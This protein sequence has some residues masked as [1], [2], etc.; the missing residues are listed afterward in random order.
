MNT[1]VTFVELF[2]GAGGLSDGFMELGYEPIAFIEQDKYCCET[3]KTR[4]AYYELKRQ[5]KLPQYNAYLRGDMSKQDFYDLANAHILD[6]VINRTID[7][8]STPEVISHITQKLAGNTLDLL[9]GGPPCQAYS[10]IGRSANQHKKADERRHLYRYYLAFLKKLSPKIFLFENVPGLLT[11]E[12]GAIYERILSDFKS[13]GYNISSIVLD[14]SHYKVLQGRKRVIIIGSKD[15]A[16]HLPRKNFKNNFK[17]ADILSDLSPLIPGAQNSRYIGRPTTYLRQTKIRTN[18]RFVTLHEAR[19]HNERDLEI[20]KLV[21]RAWNSGKKRMRYCELPTNLKTHRNESSFSDRFKVV[22]QDLPISHTMM[23]H[24][25]KDGHYY[26]HPDIEQNR[27]LSVREAA[28]VQSFP[29]NYFFEGPR[30]AKFTQIG[31]A[32]PPLVSKSIAQELAS[33]Y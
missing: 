6:K 32:V 26:I 14:A 3:L 10:I 7:S 31:N 9:L 33:Y 28:R 1:R 4:L 2:A 21:V 17:V 27:S 13:L 19:S 24:I 25:A 8:T 12:K 23:A 16:I 29:D 30:T 11:L 18:E 22:A 15:C 5:K 20:Y